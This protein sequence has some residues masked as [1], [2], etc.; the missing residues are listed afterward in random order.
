MMLPRYMNLMSENMIWL[1]PIVLE[2]IVSHLIVFIYMGFEY[3]FWNK[4]VE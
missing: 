2:I 1:A 4:K 3:L